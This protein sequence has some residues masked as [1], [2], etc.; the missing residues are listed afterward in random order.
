MGNV[1]NVSALGIQGGNMV[2]AAIVAMD[3]CGVGAR[4]GG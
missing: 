4:V 3:Y 2:R 1:N